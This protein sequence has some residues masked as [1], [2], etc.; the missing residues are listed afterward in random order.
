MI[1]DKI[2]RGDGPVIICLGALMAVVCLWVVL[3]AFRD[4]PQ[5]RRR[6]VP[7]TSWAVVL[8]ALG[9]LSWEAYFSSYDWRGVQSRL[10]SRVASNEL[11]F[12]FAEET[13]FA[14][15]RMFF[16]GPYT[17]Q[18]D[19]EKALGFKWPAYRHC[20]IKWGSDALVVFVKGHKVVYWYEQPISIDL[21]HLENEIGYSRASARFQIERTDW[22][23]LKPGTSGKLRSTAA[24][25]AGLSGHVWSFGEL[26]DRVLG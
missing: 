11:T 26:F 3:A 18:Q 16:F 10:E 6:W 22:V 21:S 8:V 14:W 25:M 24:M 23:R 7:F 19:V 4:I 20:N 17:S 9:W 1:L 15:D 5:T 13:S 2:N 12:D